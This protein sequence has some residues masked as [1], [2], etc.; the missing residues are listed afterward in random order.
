MD[1]M[2]LNSYLKKP[3]SAV[4]LAN[5]LKIPA[6]LLSQWRTGR[7]TTPAERCPSIEKAT[8]GAVTCEELR[9]DVDWAVVRGTPHADQAPVPEGAAAYTGPDRRTGAEPPHV[10]LKE[11]S[12]NHKGVS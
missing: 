1:G 3:G 10:K 4:A 12:T 2:N 5:E 6:S 7:R 9:P 11:R 8:N